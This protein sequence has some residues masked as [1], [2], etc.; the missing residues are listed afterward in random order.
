V[1]Q[2]GRAWL[3]RIARYVDTTVAPGR[4]RALPQRHRRVLA[5]IAVGV[6]LFALFVLV[7]K[8]PER[9][10]DEQDASEVLGNKPTAAADTMCGDAAASPP[11]WIADDE[12][13]DYSCMP[14]SDAS[15]WSACLQKSQYAP[16]RGAGCPARQRCCPSR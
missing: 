15:K 5:P 9:S 6:V 2:T 10:G 3:T 12:W 16:G 1:L 4:L 7:G 13:G 11:K 8:S 14:R